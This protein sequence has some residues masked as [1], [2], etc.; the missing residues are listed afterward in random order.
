MTVPSSL[1]PR[2]EDQGNEVDL[3]ARLAFLGLTVDDAARLRSMTPGFAAYADR[4]VEAFYAHLTSF[5][6]SQQ[7]LRDPRL[8]AR[9][10][11]AQRAH[12]ASLLEAAWDAEYL[13]RHVRVG[14]AHAEVGVAPQ[15]FLGAY[16]Q[17]LQNYFRELARQDPAGGAEL[18]ERQLSLLKA[19]FL[20]IGLTLEAY[21]QQS[22]MNLRQALDLFWKANVELRQFAQLTSHDL[23][24][25]LATVANLCDEALDE[26]GHA[27][28]EEARRLV[29]AARDRVF[30]MSDTISE[31]LEAAI[32]SY[33][34]E[35]ER[36]F[37]P[38]PVLLDAVER[39]RPLA[40]KQGI[41][42]SLPD[43]LPPLRGDPVRLREVL[44]N[45]L[46]NAVKF[47]ELRPGRITVTSVSTDDVCTLC[48]ADNG[49]GIPPDEL[50]RVFVPFRRLP[51]HRDRP[52]SGLGLYFAK[53]LVEQQG[54][55]IWAESAQGQGTKF[56][57]QLR[58]ARS[59]S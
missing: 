50:E 45:L 20:D 21:F 14:H 27:M 56:F 49:P 33:G 53:T 13:E 43:K 12:F 2:P 32:H 42:I 10:K 36:E 7:F 6:E 46:S 55:R 40:E 23:K 37:D 35:P 5:P 58:R 19:V 47:I 8:V 30:R 9:L 59:S 54:G 11:Q 4:F 41:A 34:D 26:F 57:V 39:V 52:G 15:L 38:G 25:P 48:V 24:T 31:L 22:T 44:G 3:P 17:Y 16:N 28:P 18:M 29:G 51:Q 1:G